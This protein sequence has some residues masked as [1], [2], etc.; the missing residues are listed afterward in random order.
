MLHYL[1]LILEPTYNSTNNCRGIFGGKWFAKTL[2]NPL[3][4]TPMQ[5]NHLPP[6]INL[7]DKV[8]GLHH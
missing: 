1:L 6:K 7:D 8:N 4:I 3:S 5:F 2:K